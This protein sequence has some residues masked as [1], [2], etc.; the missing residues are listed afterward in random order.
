MRE[1]IHTPVGL[2]STKEGGDGYALQEVKLIKCTSESPPSYTLI[3]SSTLYMFAIRKGHRQ[4]SLYDWRVRDHYRAARSLAMSRSQPIMRVLC[5]FESACSQP[6]WSKVQGLLIGTLLAR[7]RR[8]VT[9]A[10]RQM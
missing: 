3:L 2:P 9:A 5:A 6:T 4:R 1:A 7:G 10:L 8:T